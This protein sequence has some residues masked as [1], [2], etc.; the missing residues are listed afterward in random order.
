M[1]T[2]I[3]TTETESTPSAEEV[4]KPR[5][6]RTFKPKPSLRVAV[7]E[8]GPAF[9]HEGFVDALFEDHGLTKKGNS[10][11]DIANAVRAALAARDPHRVAITPLDGTPYMANPKEAE[12]WLRS[13]DDLLTEGRR[14]VIVG[15]YGV[16]EV[17][18]ITSTVAESVSNPFGERAEPPAPEPESEDNGAE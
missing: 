9:N 6:K 14:Y 18:R 3:E 13:G 5:K 16:F 8:E 15:D 11:D 1:E 2:T 10:E 7:I 12:S 17:K 4:Q